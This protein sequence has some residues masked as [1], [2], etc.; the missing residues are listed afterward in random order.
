VPLCQ[1][2]IATVA[3]FSFLQHWNEFIEP[4]ICIR[5]KEK[6]AL[7]LGLRFFQT[8]PNDAQEPRDQLLMAA[9]LIMTVPVLLF[10]ACQRYFIRGI[11]MS[12]IKG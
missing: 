6:L 11:V 4:L 3:I 7:A 12:G 2:A 5:S 8:Q 10:F 9:S 1:P